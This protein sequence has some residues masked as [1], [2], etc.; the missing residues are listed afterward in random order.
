MTKRAAPGTGSIYRHDSRALWV[1]QVTVNGR[2]Q[3]VYAPTKTEA[4]TKLNA[5]IGTGPQDESRLTVSDLLDEWLRRDV[6]GRRI[7]PT[8]KERHE[9]SVKRMK[10]L[11]GLQRASRLTVRDVEAMLD[12]MMDDGAARATMSKT[13][14]ALAQALDYGA[15]R[16]VVG[17][18]VARLAK[19]PP[20]APGTDKRRSLDADEARRLLAALDSE[21]LGLMFAL[22]LKLGLRPGEA[23][24]LRWSDTD[25]DAGT[26]TVCRTV[27]VR[28]NR[29]DVVKA[30]KTAASR[31]TLRL[32][33]DV[34]ADLRIHRTR[35]AAERL[36]AASWADDRLV[37]A[38]E[39][40]TVIH[41]R[42]SRRTLT[43]ICE[44]AK[45]DPAIRPNELR[46]SCASYLSDQGVPHTTIADLLG[47]TS[48]RMVDATYRHRIRDVVDVPSVNWRAD[49]A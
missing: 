19:L 32:P 36:A 10:P 9:W 25:L 44:R 39:V 29:A 31:R 23:A 33:D 27:R 16:D 48:T 21:R 11:I 40:G 45:I 35:Q 2:R 38:S 24:A 1:G 42:N 20:D 41:P 14:G 26:L 8:T 43:A 6:A 4:R 17:R 22:G 46:H 7:A 15:A 49:E 28:A 5:I 13:L 3:R 37:F 30:T 18:N 34:A 12:S 47:H